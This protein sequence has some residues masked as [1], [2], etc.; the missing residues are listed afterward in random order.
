L[1]RLVDTAFLIYEEAVSGHDT[2]WLDEQDVAAV[3]HITGQGLRSVVTIHGHRSFPELVGLP[4]IDRSTSFNADADLGAVR[5][6]YEIVLD[7]HCLGVVSDALRKKWRRKVGPRYPGALFPT[8]DRLKARFANRTAVE[9]IGDLNAM[10]QRWLRPLATVSTP[11]E[12]PAN[13]TYG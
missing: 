9:A 12:R 3:A 5:T 10:K 7:D 6:H 13:P 1:E 8:R 11:P 2:I 4:V